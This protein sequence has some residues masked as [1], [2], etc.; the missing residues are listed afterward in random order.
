VLDQPVRG[1]KDSKAVKAAALLAPEDGLAVPGVFEEVEF[2]KSKGRRWLARDHNPM[3]LGREPK[4]QSGSV[5]GAVHDVHA[6][7]GCKCL[8]LL[9]A[10]GF[11]H[12][13]TRLADAH[14]HLLPRGLESN[15]G[16]VLADKARVSQ[17]VQVD[18]L[19]VRV[20]AWRKEVLNC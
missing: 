2:I 15:D 12:R 10:S 5:A 13:F 9:V 1:I 3:D 20:E 18:G 19:L 6:P 17:A 14:R 4:A 7:L 16:F 11:R 8:E